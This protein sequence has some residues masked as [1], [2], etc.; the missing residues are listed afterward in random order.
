MSQSFFFLF[1]TS[2]A[3]ILNLEAG[4]DWMN[5]FTASYESVNWAE[6]AELHSNINH[7]LKLL[8]LY[9]WWLHHVS[10]RIV[11]FRFIL[12]NIFKL[13]FLPCTCRVRRSFLKET[14]RHISGNVCSFFSRSNCCRNCAKAIRKKKKSAVIRKETVMDRHAAEMQDG[15]RTRCLL[16][17]FIPAVVL[18]SFSL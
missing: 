16:L 7:D 18:H 10:V 2:L 5:R 11:L 13:F 17:C 6:V 14:V 9:I 1:Q 4:A 3:N 8:C 12:S 15:T